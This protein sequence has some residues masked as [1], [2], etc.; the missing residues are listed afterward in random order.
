M[1]NNLDQYARIFQED[2]AA[3]V[4]PEKL[5][6]VLQHGTFNNPQWANSM[7]WVKGEPAGS[8]YKGDYSATLAEL[9][10]GAL[11]EPPKSVN[12]LADQLTATLTIANIDRRRRRIAGDEGDINIPRWIDDRD[13]RLFTRRRRLPQPAP[14]VNIFASIAF[15]CR[16]K[17][18]RYQE[19]AAAL[20]AVS[21]AMEQAGFASNIYTVSTASHALKEKAVMLYS[22]KQAGTPLNIA[23]VWTYARP[24]VSRRINHCMICAYCDFF[25]LPHMSTLGIPFNIDNHFARKITGDSVNVIIPTNAIEETAN[26]P[27]AL[28][29]V[30]QRLIDGAFTTTNDE[31]E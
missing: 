21:Q 14:I 29:Y 16:Q 3:V 24:E 5:P 8:F 10:S 12:K 28:A 27:A 4:M 23:Q 25:N 17:I 18:Q 1:Q 22:I 15:S 19:A 6:Q 9:E 11:I 20:C 31:Q 26:D 13:D 7:Q 2:A 30:L